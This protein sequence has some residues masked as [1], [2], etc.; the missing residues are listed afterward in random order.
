M[1][2]VGQAE[3]RRAA[4]TGSSRRCRARCAGRPGPT[5]QRSAS[6]RRPRQSGSPSGAEDAHLVDPAAEVGRHADVG[7]GGHD[8]LADARARGRGRSARGRTP[9]AWTRPRGGAVGRRRHGST[10]RA[11]GRGRR[12]ASRARGRGAQRAR[13]ASPASKRVPLV[14]RR[15]AR[16]VAAQLVDLLAGEQR[17]VVERAPGDRQAAALDRVGED[18]RRPVGCGRRVP[19]SASQ[20]VAQVVPAEVAGSATRRPPRSGSSARPQ[21]RTARPATACARAPRSPSARPR[22]TATGTPRSAS[23]RSACAGRAPPSRANAA[24][25]RRPYFSS[26]TCQPAASNPRSSRAALMPGTTRSRHWRLRSTIQST[27]PRPCGGR[28]GDRLPDVALVE[29]GV[30][31]QRDEAAARPRRPKCAST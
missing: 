6:G 5:R 10:G 1:Q 18:H 12:I 19:A 17:G 4:G 29:L 30:A 3:L 24:R 14:V 27:L 31:E 13:P 2:L 8:P 21:R 11:A 20:Q 16:S 9:P 15:R 26:T 25:S 28:V 7:R 23:R 22:R